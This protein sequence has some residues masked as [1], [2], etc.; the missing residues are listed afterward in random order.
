MAIPTPALD[1]LVQLMRENRIY[2][3]PVDVANLVLTLYRER[4]PMSNDQGLQQ[5]VERLAIDT[6]HA[7][8]GP[9]Q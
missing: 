2:A 9:A 1:E 3:E 5:W 7:R 4:H 8:T 6:L